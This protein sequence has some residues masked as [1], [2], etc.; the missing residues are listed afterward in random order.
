MDR[1][2]VV[3]RL[4]A[5][6]AVAEVVRMGVRE[7]SVTWADMELGREVRELG[8]GSGGSSDMLCMRRLAARLGIGYRA[9]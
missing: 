2:V 8:A 4:R 9:C 6:E 3:R 1:K 5:W 7:E